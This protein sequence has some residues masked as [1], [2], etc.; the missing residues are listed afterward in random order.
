[1][2]PTAKGAMLIP[3]GKKMLSERPRAKDFRERAAREVRA[4]LEQVGVILYVDVSR[5]ELTL[6]MPGLSRERLSS[7]S[8]RLM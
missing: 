4:A 1:M 8:A 5:L 6:V 7:T 3:P 2:K